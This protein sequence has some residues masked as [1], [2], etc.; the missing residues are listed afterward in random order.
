MK[1]RIT[2]DDY[3]R[4]AS[5]LGCEPAAIE[6]VAE[7]E[8]SGSGFNPDESCKTLFEGHH[9]HRL[10]EGRFDASHPTLSFPKW[11][12]EWYGKTWQDEAYRLEI[13]VGLDREAALMAASWG[14][15]QIMG[16][17]FG[18]AGFRSVEAFVAAMNEGEPQQLES[19]VSIIRAWGLADELRDCRWADFAR[20]YNGPAFKANHYDD[21]MQL[22]YKRARYAREGK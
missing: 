11:T 2:G 5:R 10:T 6:A 19:F 12:R 16:F 22:A 21:K 15:F 9:F 13:A 17:N 3:V 18:A 20:R 1:Q 7:V 8:S 14:R 4:A